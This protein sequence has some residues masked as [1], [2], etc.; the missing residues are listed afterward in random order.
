MK[1]SELQQIIKEEIKKTINEG[2]IEDKVADLYA[3]AG[4][5][6]SYD[7]KMIDK[8]GQATIQKAVEM[9]PKV[10]AYQ[11][12]LKAMANEIK[13]SPEGKMLLAMAKANQLYSGDSGPVSIGDI[14]NL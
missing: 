7:S 5:R 9:A 4:V 2:S 8:Y 3:Y 13:T 14:F 10:L 1:K 12:K 6:T 11:A